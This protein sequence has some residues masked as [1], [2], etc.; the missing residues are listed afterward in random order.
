MPLSWLTCNSVF[1]GF[2]RSTFRSAIQAVPQPVR[3]R[4]CQLSCHRRSGHN[5]EFKSA[6]H[7][8]PPLSRN[9][10]IGREDDL[11]R[12]WTSLRPQPSLTRRQVAMVHG[13]DGVGKSRLAMHFSELHKGDF[14]SI[15]WAHGKDKN[16]VLA[17][18]AALA[19]RVPTDEA[20]STLRINAQSKCPTLEGQASMVLEWLS[21]EENSQ[22]LLIFDDVVA[23]SDPSVESGSGDAFSIRDFFPWSD[24]GSI[25]AT[26]TEPG[27]D[28]VGG[29]HA[30][31]RLSPQES[32]QLFDLGIESPPGD[33]LGGHVEDPARKLLV[34]QLDGLPLALTQA[35]SY[36]RQTGQSIS[37]YQRLFQVTRQTLQETTEQEY[38]SAV[39]T[40]A[41]SFEQIH[42]S[43]PLAAKLL[44]LFS[45]YNN[46][47]IPTS[48]LECE[49]DDPALPNWFGNSASLEGRFVKELRTLSDF[50]L[51]TSLDNNTGTCSMHPAVKRWCQGNIDAKE[52]EELNTAAL[53]L[54]GRAAAEALTNKGSPAGNQ[55][56][57]LPH[58]NEMRRILQSGS[59]VV[60]SNEQSLLAIRNLG[61]LYKDQGCL[62]HAEYMYLCALSRAQGLFGQSH[63]SPLVRSCSGFE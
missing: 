26:T 24:N 63:V 45:C 8:E 49:R 36:I 33:G 22:W 52:A 3:L 55:Q 54:L 37:S 6:L 4:A 60:S 17:S 58:A 2:S 46:A 38:D 11:I 53:I 23:D 47:G 18:L 5:A 40:C 7:K 15:W 10:F 42:Q 21:R 43:H 39:V 32:L 62:A 35:A 51:I 28:E 56:L 9:A 44:L 13:P 16:S 61:S 27:M 34:H 19:S 41:L 59:G 31:S 20:T 50:S 1:L 30:L 48:L 57:L 14:C 12:I 29:V 25:L